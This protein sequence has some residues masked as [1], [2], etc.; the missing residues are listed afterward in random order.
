M[1]RYGILAV[2]LLAQIFVG[3]AALAAVAPAGK[4]VGVNPNATGV[5][6]EETRTLVVGS[7]V[8][9]GEKIV[10]GSS[11]QVQLIF[12]DDTRLVVGPA[13]SLVVESYLL[14]NDKSVG[15][16]AVNAL[17]G[18][19]RFITGQSDHSAYRI[20]TPTGTIGV[21]GTAF[22]FTVAKDGGPPRPPAG[23]FLP[24][25]TVA[26]FSGAVVLCNLQKQCI[27]L[28]GRC[29]VGQIRTPEA[30]KIGPFDPNAEGLRA[31]FRYIASQRPLMQEFRINESRL[32]FE[33]TPNANSLS[34]PI[35]STG[36]QNPPP[37]RTSQDF[38][39]PGG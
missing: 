15:Q 38:G 35:P 23:Q 27:V 7:D 12:N 37:P 30:S 20:D 1:G 25:T 3:S 28:T 13:S 31:R 22:D 10:T 21:R 36:D 32:C 8:A 34:T 19:F 6:K 18:T 24:G 5:V 26:L 29:D 14:R 17:G 4:A 11:G 39:G 2:A 16:F 33:Q 9:I